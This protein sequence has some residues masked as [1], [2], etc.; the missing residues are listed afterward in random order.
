MTCQQ[1]DVNNIGG[2]VPCGRNSVLGSSSSEKFASDDQSSI[3]LR[4][5]L[6]MCNLVTSFV[7]ESLA[8]ERSP[9]MCFSIGIAN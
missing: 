5:S 6:Y 9:A 2:I 7:F 4:F 3:V 8:D 1:S